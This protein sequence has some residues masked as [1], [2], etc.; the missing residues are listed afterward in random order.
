MR[1][2]SVQQKTV[3][4]LS[5]CRSIH[6]TASFTG[7]AGTNPWSM[8]SDPPAALHRRTGA[9][10]RC[11]AIAGAT[12]GCL[13][14]GTIRAQRCG[15]G[16][17]ADAPAGTETLVR[18]SP[19]L[20]LNGFTPALQSRSYSPVDHN[21]AI[22][23]RGLVLQNHGAS[24]QYLLYDQIDSTLRHSTNRSS[25]YLTRAQDKIEFL[26]HCTRTSTG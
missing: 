3:L 2:R 22:S 6:R 1:N 11:G 5:A 14:P 20:G 26:S 8:A 23:I 15:T 17:R 7:S 9:G 13:P 4:P 19:A 25:R 21:T 18:P 12:I 24:H 16:S 10:A